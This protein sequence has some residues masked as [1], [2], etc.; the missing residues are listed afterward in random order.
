MFGI[1]SHVCELSIEARAIK[2][3]KKK[4]KLHDALPFKRCEMILILKKEDTMILNKNK[5]LKFYQKI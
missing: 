1:F 5:I 4:K 3:E 2:K